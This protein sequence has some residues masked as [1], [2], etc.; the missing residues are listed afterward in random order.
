MKAFL[1]LES[2]VEGKSADVRDGVRKLC[3]PVL[4]FVH[5]LKSGK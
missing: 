2:P 1:S 4:L 3:D 5:L